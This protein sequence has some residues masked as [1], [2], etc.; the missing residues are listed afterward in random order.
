MK[1]DDGDNR[2]W[3]Q[4]DLRVN[5]GNFREKFGDELTAQQSKYGPC[6]DEIEDPRKNSKDQLAI[7]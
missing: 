6:S 2:L 5:H 3:G 1:S 4:I 7:P